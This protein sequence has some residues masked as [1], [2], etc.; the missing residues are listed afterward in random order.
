MRES[1]AGSA[2]LRLP[3]QQQLFVER[4]RQRMSRKGGDRFS[5]KDM[6]QSTNLR[7]HPN[8]DAL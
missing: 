2:F 5:E 3:R 8:R 6:R 4:G 1:T 7:A